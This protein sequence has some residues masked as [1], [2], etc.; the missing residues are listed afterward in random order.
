[1]STNDFDYIGLVGAILLAIQNLPQ[2]YLLYKKKSTEEISWAFLLIGLVAASLLA[3]SA[4]KH[5]VLTFIIANTVCLFTMTIIFFQKI[6][7]ENVFFTISS[8]IKY[9]FVLYYYILL[10]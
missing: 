2:I 9:L 8:K 6:F 7:Y 3:S 5:N 1:M 4:Y 10:Y